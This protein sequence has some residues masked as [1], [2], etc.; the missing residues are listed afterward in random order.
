MLVEIGLYPTLEATQRQIDGF[1]SQLRPRIWWHLWKIN[2]R[3]A[4]TVWV[5]DEADAGVGSGA[6]SR[7]VQSLFQGCQLLTIGSYFPC[8]GLGARIWGYRQS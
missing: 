6:A 4:P 5:V 3:F 1:F 8:I 2:L 7:L